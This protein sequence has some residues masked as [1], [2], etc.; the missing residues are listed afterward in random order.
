MRDFIGFDDC[1]HNWVVI[2]KSL[3]LLIITFKHDYATNKAE[4]D[5]KISDKYDTN[6]SQEINGILIPFD[7]YTSKVMENIDLLIR[8]L[9]ANTLKRLT[10]IL[11]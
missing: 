6:C 9:R 1:Q 10:V 7:V 11:V 8:N 5:N 4:Q 3:R 2:N